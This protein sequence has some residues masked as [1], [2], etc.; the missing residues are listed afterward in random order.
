[1][2]WKPPRSYLGKW[3]R[4]AIEIVHRSTGMVPS[5]SYEESQSKKG[6]HIRLGLSRPV[7]DGQALMLQFLLGDDRTRCRLNLERAR[8]GVV[9][10][11]KFFVRKIPRLKTKKEQVDE[12]LDG[13]PGTGEREGEIEGF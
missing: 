2:D 3:Q 7:T 13:L 4:W 5:F 10:W 8:A 1:M 9:D 11:N 6:L 12:F